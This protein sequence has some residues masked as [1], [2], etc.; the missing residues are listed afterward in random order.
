MPIIMPNQ[1]SSYI[2]GRVSPSI[3]DGFQYNE[4]THTEASKIKDKRQ[5]HQK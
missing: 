2:Q 3:Q 1:P 5:V 4:M